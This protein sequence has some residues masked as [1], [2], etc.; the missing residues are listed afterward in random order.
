MV[1]VG[2]EEEEDD[3]DDGGGE[4]GLV[5]AVVF[6]VV[7]FV[8][9]ESESGEIGDGKKK[10]EQGDKEG[11]E[12]KE[13]LVGAVTVERDVGAGAA[14]TMA[15]DKR[16]HSPPSSPHAPSSSSPLVFFLLTAS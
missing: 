1:E 16:G 2:E 4:V 13:V 7:V 15:V 14:T 12:E 3:D 10:G 11:E 9:V 5:A 6:V 8:V